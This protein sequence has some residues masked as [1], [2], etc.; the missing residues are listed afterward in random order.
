[1]EKQTFT[2]YLVSNG[3]LRHTAHQ[4]NLIADH[5]I[6]WVKANKLNIRK[7]KR[8]EFTEWAEQDRQL[9]NKES[10]IRFK[11]RIIDHYYNYLKAED[12]PT[13]RWVQ[14]RRGQTLPDSPFT[15]E[16]L[17]SFYE[18]LQPVTPLQHQSRCLLGTVLFQALSTAEIQE[19]RLQDINIKGT[20]YI[21]GQLRTNAR[22]LELE[23]IQ[24]AHLHEYINKYRS[25]FLRFKSGDNDKLFLPSR[26]SNNI[27]NLHFRI[28]KFLRKDFP[29]IKAARHLRSSVIVNWINDSGVMEALY[30]SGMRY[31]TSLD[32]YQTTDY[33]E[34][35]DILRT[36]HPLESMGF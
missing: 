36:L 32:R 10:T 5:Y 8:S 15:K 1:M 17:M 22:T 25:E 29:Q 6:K 34:L 28:I 19:L 16:E 9:N 30:N 21:E 26:T 11:E 33:D 12:K 20:I 23:G 18:S 13:I 4:H 24:I 3:M 27:D 14:S 2:D 35:E 7:M 31:V